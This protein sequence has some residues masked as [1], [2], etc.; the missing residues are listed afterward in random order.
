MLTI[1][2]TTVSN[3]TRFH[4]WAGCLKATD[5]TNAGRRGKTCREFTLSTWPNPMDLV[6]I[7]GSIVDA[8]D[9]D[10]ARTA[11]IAT[12]MKFEERP[13]RAIDVEPD[14]SNVTEFEIK[15]FHNGIKINGGKLIKGSFSKNVTTNGK[16]VVAFYASEYQ[17]PAIFYKLFEVRNN[18]ETMTDYFE[19]DSIDFT[20]E[21]PFYGE[22]LAAAD[23][24]SAR[25]AARKVA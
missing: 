13:L 19:R 25:W 11:A 10:A 22:A 20:S 7:S 6:C 8:V 4:M 17:N 12:G 21:H 14:Y 9:F 24:K 5:L 23:A 16:P 15:F 3:G 2:Q 1:G 18:T